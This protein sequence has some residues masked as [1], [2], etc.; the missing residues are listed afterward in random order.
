MP[1]TSSA[2]CFCGVRA[3][4]EKRGRGLLGIVD[5][6]LGKL[7]RQPVARREAGELV[8]RRELGHGDRAR[9]Q[10]AQCGVGKIGRGHERHLTADK[11]AK[12]EVGGL[13][14]ADILELAQ[15]IGDADGDVLELDGIGGVGALGERSS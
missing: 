3:L 8:L 9:R 14:A 11:N 4:D 13:R 7:R 15:A 6:E 2:A 12:P 1:G 5:L 10:L